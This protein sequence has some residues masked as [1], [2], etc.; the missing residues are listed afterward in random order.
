MSEHGAVGRI[1]AIDA[2]RGVA[3][4]AMMVFHLGW[5]LVLV[6]L[7]SVPAD[8][9]LFWQAFPRGI[10]SAFLLIAGV[11][12]VLAHRAGFDRRRFW[13]RFG[14]LA[15]AA[16][17]VT[18]VTWAVF[19]DSFIFFGVL[20]AMAAFSL[21]GLALL[22]ARVRV[23]VVLA[24]CVLAIGMAVRE[25]VFQ[26]PGLI[27]L[28][29]AAVPPASND[30]VPPFPF[31]AVFLAGMA[32]GRIGLDRGWFAAGWTRWPATGPVGG[33]L[34]WL[35]RWSLVIYLGHQP[36]FLAVLF[37]AVWLLRG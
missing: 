32:L 25:E 18:A 27:W 11:S 4:L 17:I 19:P 14:V 21:V 12:L 22:T 9:A 10:V 35:G 2:I 23:L 37:G 5:D 34:R 7:P 31:L 6:G 29:L 24:A 30:F 20:H 36:L 28:G 26:H 33:G 8:N 1:P 3:M 16:G 15:L 13:R